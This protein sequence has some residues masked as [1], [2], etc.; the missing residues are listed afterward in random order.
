MQF[1]LKQGRYLSRHKY[2]EGNRY[3]ETP[4]PTFRKVLIIFLVAFLGMMLLLL[5]IP[6]ILVLLA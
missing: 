1:N 2:A 4:K 6:Y 5:G 3:N